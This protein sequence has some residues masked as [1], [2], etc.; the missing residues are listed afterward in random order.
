[1]NSLKY[2]Q[3]LLLSHELH[4]INY[5]YYILCTRDLMSVCTGQA[6]S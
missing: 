1:M 5:M 2:N 3:D 6:Y 4:K